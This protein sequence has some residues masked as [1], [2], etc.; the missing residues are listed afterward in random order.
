MN[1]KCLEEFFKDITGFG[2]K[3]SGAGW[4]TKR[5]QKKLAHL[6]VEFHKPSTDKIV[7]EATDRDITNI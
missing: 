3:G 7:K 6:T 1:S 5:I 2:N 4:L